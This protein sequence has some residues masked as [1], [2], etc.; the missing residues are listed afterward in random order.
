LLAYAAVVTLSRSAIVHEKWGLAIIAATVLIYGVWCVVHTQRTMT[1]FR[2]RLFHIYQTYFTEEERH[3]Y[4][5]W[6]CKPTV[7]HTPQVF[8]GLVVVQFLSAIVAI[9]LIVQGVPLWRQAL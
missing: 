9:Y 3:V 7:N 1:R 2:S 6:N 5:M 8:Y 4:E